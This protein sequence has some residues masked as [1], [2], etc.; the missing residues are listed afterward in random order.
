MN[1]FF[2]ALWII[3]A[4]FTIITVALLGLVSNALLEFNTVLSSK[5]A[6]NWIGGFLADNAALEALRNVLMV[7][8]IITIV[9][10]LIMLIVAIATKSRENAIILEYDEGEVV[11]TDTAVKSNVVR[12]LSGFDN[13]RSPEVDARIYNKRNPKI[14]VDLDCY[15][16]QTTNIDQLGIAIQEKIKIGLEH[17]THVPVED[18]RVKFHKPKRRKNKSRV[19]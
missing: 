14:R 9:G 4:L 18:V 11:I 6:T 5:I 8:A 7:L 12:S 16:N 13:I 17:M 3:L 15:T 2:K 19:V 1:K 10:N